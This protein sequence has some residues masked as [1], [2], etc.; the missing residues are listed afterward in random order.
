MAKKEITCPT[1]EGDLLLTGDE[2]AGDEIYCPACNAPAKLVADAND[3]Q[4]EAEAD[5]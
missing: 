3:E 4:C 5:Y 1:C 2:Q